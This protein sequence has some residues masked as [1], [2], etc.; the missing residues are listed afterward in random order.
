LIFYQVENKG[1][2]L[3]TNE[4][5]SAEVKY[6]DLNSLNQNNIHRS[7]WNIIELIKYQKQL[8]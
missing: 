5:D 7:C 1:G 3:K 2:E 4:E 6:F 8:E